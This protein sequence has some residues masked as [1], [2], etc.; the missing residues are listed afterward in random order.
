MAANLRMLAEESPDPVSGSDSASTSPSQVEVAAFQV[1]SAAQ[2]QFGAVLPV[3]A[4]MVQDLW[5][6]EEQTAQPSEQAEQ[7]SPV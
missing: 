6:L 2:E 5:Q 3:P 4:H 7:A 1:S